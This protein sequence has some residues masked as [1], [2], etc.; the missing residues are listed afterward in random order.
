MATG[1]LE[2]KIIVFCML[3]HDLCFIAAD[4][5]VLLNADARYIS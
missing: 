5:M 2:E 4:N 1:E 3:F